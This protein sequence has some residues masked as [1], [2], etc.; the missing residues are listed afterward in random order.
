VSLKHVLAL[1][2]LSIPMFGVTQSDQ[3]TITSILEQ[4]IPS[5]ELAALQLQQF[6]LKKAPLL[7]APSSAQEWTAQAE[8]TRQRL[9]DDVLF[10]GWPREWVNSLPHFEDIGRIPS[11]PGYQIHKLRYEVVP[12]FYATALLYEPEHL[13]GKMPAVL[14]AMGHFYD[15][16][17]AQEFAQTLSI[18]LALRG[19]IVLNPDWIGMGELNVSGNDHWFAAHL[20]LV[21]ANGI[22]LFYLAMRRC[23]DY[24]SD[25]PNVDTNRIGMTG[26]SGGGW[27]T[28]ILSSLDPR[29]LVAIPVAGY[30]S[31]PGRVE[32][33]PSE[34]GDLEQN[35]TDLL[36]GQDYSTLTALRAPRPTLL[37]YNAEDDC[38]FRAP[39]VKPDIYDAIQPFFHLYGNDKDFLFYQSTAIS[40]HNYGSANREAA[41]RFFGEHFHLA[42]SDSETPVG[43][44]LKAFDE[45]R[46]GVPEDNLTILGLARQFAHGLNR[47][48]AISKVALSD[49][50]RYH[51]VTVGRAWLLANS[52][53]NQL[54]TLSYRFEFTNGL[55]AVGVWLKHVDATPN[56]PLTIVLDDEGK[57]KAAKEMLD[58][59]PLIASRLERGEQVLVM[60]LLFTGDAAPDNSPIFAEMLAATG[61]RPL[62]METAQLIGVGMWANATLHPDALRI[63]SIGIRSQVISLIAS[64]L[65][66]NLFS[67][68]SIHS[69]M[70]SFAYLLDQPIHYD[71][72][73][74]LFCLDLYKDFDIDQLEQLSA[75]TRINSDHY[76]E[77]RSVDKPAQ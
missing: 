49:V 75:P 28:I 47:P 39:L 16:G 44:Y 51:D 1:F 10:H 21:G 68:I 33:I 73:P 65:A 58:G 11:G 34:P 38:C 50:I 35:A 48:H 45:L 2:I 54:E 60:D 41:Y 4:P 52:Y 26:L 72:A 64:D 69:G 13:V 59:M 15:G 57:S 12:G 56:A 9:L 46:F 63:E 43:Q 53:H 17:N 7:P 23:L 66:S 30:T 67:A 37:L 32:R 70:H 76:V 29:I 71:A 55:S 3:K 62:G 42:T 74:D 6:L 19:M 27:Q 61:E 24:L 5:R 20:D 36:V 77:V 25:D 31:L 18:N 22:G 8:H 40:A 14:H